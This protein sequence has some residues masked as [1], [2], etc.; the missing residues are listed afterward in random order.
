MATNRLAQSG[1]KASEYGLMVWCVTPEPG[2]PIKT[3]LEDPSYWAHISAQFLKPDH[4]IIVRDPER[5]Y[6]LHLTVRACGP[7]WARVAQLSLHRFDAPKEEA[8]QM[9]E[10]N[11]Y[12]VVFAGAAKWRVIRKADRSV[13]IQDLGSRKAA[14][15]WLREH[16]KSI[17]PAA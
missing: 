1:L 10:T 4:D 15:E 5:T 16:L 6:R 9:P 12:E 14:A 13:M 8:V 17:A 3:I 7:N 11:E 2:T